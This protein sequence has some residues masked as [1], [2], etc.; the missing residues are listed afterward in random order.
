LISIACCIKDKIWV[1]PN[2][3]PYWIN[4]NMPNAGPHLS[5]TRL[6]REGLVQFIKYP[7]SSVWYQA[8]KIGRLKRK[9]NNG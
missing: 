4:N 1:P 5:D 9:N 7:F 8:H 6:K 2:G 3:R